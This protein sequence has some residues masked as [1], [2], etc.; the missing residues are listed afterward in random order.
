MQI[1]FSCQSLWVNALLRHYFFCSK[2]YFFCSPERHQIPDNQAVRRQVPCTV[3]RSR[4]T[5]AG[6]GIVSF[7]LGIVTC[8]VPCTIEPMR[9][10]S[11]VTHYPL[12]FSPQTSPYWIAKHLLQ[13]TPLHL[14][15]LRQQSSS[16]QLQ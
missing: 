16:E 3:S 7:V 15:P 8:P 4:I 6:I 9:T 5:F 2:C 11:S 14:R 1:S 13:M 10:D 12:S